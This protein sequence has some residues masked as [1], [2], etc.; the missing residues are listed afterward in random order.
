VKTPVYKVVKLYK[1]G[2]YFEWCIHIFMW[3]FGTIPIVMF[4]WLRHGFGLVDQFIESSLVA[5][6]ISS[7][8]LLITVIPHGHGRCLWIS[9]W[10][11]QFSKFGE[12]NRVT[13]S[14]LRTLFRA[15]S[16]YVWVCYLLFH[17]CYKIV[18]VQ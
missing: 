18:V 11:F 15:V 7:N 1:T 3:I 10:T 12:F 13:I 16:E 9:Q 17:Q 5:T 4:Q 6:T 8:T 14:F 2:W